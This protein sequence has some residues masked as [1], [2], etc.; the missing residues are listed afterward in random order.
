MS[1]G[2]MRNRRN[3]RAQ[4]DKAHVNALA[5]P[6]SS[7]RASW[8]IATGDTGQQWLREGSSVSTGSRQQK[9]E[10]LGSPLVS[11]ARSAA[12]VAGDRK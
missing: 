3:L 1:R 9:V 7:P 10:A 11:P 2:P 4:H 8:G 5:T 12:Q 6:T